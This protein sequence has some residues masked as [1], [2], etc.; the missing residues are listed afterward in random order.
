MIFY[1]LGILGY[2]KA[3]NK[4]VPAGICIAF[5]LVI[6]IPPIT[7]LYLLLNKHWLFQA[8]ALAAGWFCWTFIE[9][10]IHRFR[11]HKKDKSHYH[12]SLHF[13]HHT[14]PRKIFTTET[15]RVI[16][17]VTAILF[18]YASIQFSSYLFLPSGVVAGFALYGYMHVGL[19][20]PAMSRWISKH[21]DFHLQ[22]HCGKTETCFGVTVTWWDKIFN[23]I[24]RSE[25]IIN[26]KTKEFYF[27]K[28]K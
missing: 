28:T 19:H 12:A 4:P 23:T 8:I 7:T 20:K 16:V 5:F 17:A 11:M 22:H 1:L 13:I 14:N 10:F 21:Q 25:K 26:Q 9:Y 15:R 24:N 27:R 2:Y 6:A 3:R 18:I